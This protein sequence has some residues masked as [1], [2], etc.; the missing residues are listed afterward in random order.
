MRDAACDPVDVLLDRRDHVG[1]DGGAA[2]TGDQEE[3]REARGP[4]PEVGAGAFG[5]LLPERPSAFAADVHG[6]ERAGHGVEA[7][8][9][10]DAI[11]LVDRLLRAEAVRQDLL[12][13]ILVDV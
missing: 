7:R 6:E 3:I 4:E 1:E 9:E 13:R 8:R 12:Y 5:P 2:G 11:D 10:D